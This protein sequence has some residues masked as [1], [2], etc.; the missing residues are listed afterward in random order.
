MRET[1][2]KIILEL[3]DQG[4]PLYK[5][6]DKDL[7]S[8]FN[9]GMAVVIIGPRRAGKSYFMY[10]IMD[11]LKRPIKDYICINFEDNRLADFTYKNFDDILI[12]YNELYP[13][14]KPIFFLDEVHNVDKWWLFVRRLVDKKYEVFITGSNAHLLSKEY[15]THLGGRALETVL[16]PLSFKE[17]LKFKNINYDKNIIHSN[18]RFKILNEFKEYIAFGGFPQLVLNKNKDAKQMILNSYFNTV[19]YRDIIARYNI[20]DENVFKL[21]LKKVAE[22]VG[23]PFTYRSLENIIRS[24]DYDVTRKTLINY[25]EACIEAFFILK[26]TVAKESVKKREMQRKAYLID[27]GYLK[28]FYTN[29]NFGKLLENSVATYFYTKYNKLNYFRGKNEVD[30]ILPDNTPVQVC[31]DLDAAY[32]REIKALIGY[33]KLKNKKTGYIITWN[34]YDEIKKQGY[35]IKLIP[36]YYFMLFSYLF[37]K[38]NKYL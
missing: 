21:F 9:T 1:I 17:F 7:K 23:N 19:V 24:L 27:T 32:D 34:K 33:L 2:K 25:S 26:S 28:L 13:N 15:S 5:K 11:E 31:Y 36:A 8:L 30:F 4:L 22:N 38:G 3:H 16:F 37:L 20:E 6:R 29:E 35:K 14:K 18:K 12:A 10:Q